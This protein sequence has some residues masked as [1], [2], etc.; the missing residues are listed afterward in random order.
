MKKPEHHNSGFTVFEALTAAVIISVLVAIALP[1]FIR[2]KDRAYEASIETNA[3]TLRIML[4]NYK[5]DQS[6]YPEDLRTLGREATLR[7]YN[8]TLTNPISQTGGLV[9]NGAWAVMYTGPTGPAGMVTYNPVADKYYIFGYD[10][11]GKLHQKAG[12]V[13]QMTNG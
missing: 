2:S 1:N 7:G 3:R 10:A 8:K 13:F 6:V 9:E 12:E 11:E 4:E 5:V